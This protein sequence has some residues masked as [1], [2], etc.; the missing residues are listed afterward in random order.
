MCGHK[1]DIGIEFQKAAHEDLE[2]LLRVERA[3][4][5][6]GEHVLQKGLETRP[7]PLPH[8]AFLEADVVEEAEDCGE[9]FCFRGRG[10]DLRVEGE[11]HIEESAAAGED[12]ID[13][14]R[15]F[16]ADV[17]DQ[18]CSLE[19]GRVGLGAEALPRLLCDGG[20]E[21]GKEVGVRDEA[22]NGGHVPPLS[23]MGVPSVEK[24]VESAEIL[25]AM[26]S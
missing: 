24:Q 9:G 2:L 7:D 3:K 23:G 1:G 8:A 20:L 11:E 18:L 26:L 19:G 15:V 21:F 12:V 6:M 25:L 22:G 16:V 5:I 10:L 4:L 17:S 14:M 13:E